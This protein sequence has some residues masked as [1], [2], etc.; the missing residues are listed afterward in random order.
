MNFISLQFAAIITLSLASC[1]SKNEQFTK[2]LCYPADRQFKVLNINDEHLKTFNEDLKVI[3]R[4]HFLRGVYEVKGRTAY[5][6]VY[7]GEK[8]D[9]L[10]HALSDRNLPKNK[11]GEKYTWW[12][13]D[14]TLYLNS[15]DQLVMVSFPANLSSEF[16]PSNESSILFELC[17]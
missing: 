16:I 15:R 3:A 12:A 17:D 8:K 9:S 10:L 2:D 13:A 14:S 5:A 7:E 1:S 11:L 4:G 6:S